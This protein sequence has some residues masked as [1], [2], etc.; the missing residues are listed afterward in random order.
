MPLVTFFSILERPG[1]NRKG[2]C[3]NPPLVRR[4]LM[5]FV[6]RSLVW[7]WV[8]WGGVGGCLECGWVGEFWML[9]LAISMSTVCLTEFGQKVTW[10]S[11][12]KTLFNYYLLFNFYTTTY[13]SFRV[14]IRMV[15]LCHFE[16]SLPDSSFFMPTCPCGQFQHLVGLFQWHLW[17][18]LLYFFLPLLK[19]VF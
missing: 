12:G 3:N 2:V 1:K 4:G 17:R 6:W 5:R 9:I 8:C 10:V 15:F 7:R 18:L 16:V 11:F 19:D 13:P 14:F